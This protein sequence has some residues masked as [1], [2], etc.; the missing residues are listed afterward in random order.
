MK[1]Y[2]VLLMVDVKKRDL[3]SLLLI[4]SI[5]K[6]KYNCDVF[7]CRNGLEKMYVYRFKID[8][9]VITNAISPNLKKLCKSLKKIG[10]KIIILPSEGFHKRLVVKK[11]HASGGI[12]M[13]H[14]YVDKIF[15]WNNEMFK[16]FLKYK[17]I[18]PKNLILSGCQRLD[19]Y[20]NKFKLL[21]KKI[22]DLNLVKKK[23]VLLIATNYVQADR[24]QMDRISDYEKEIKSFNIEFKN[25]KELISR[26]KNDQKARLKLC[27]LILKISKLQKY[28]IILKVHPFENIFF[29]VKFIKE[30]NIKNVSISEND[31]IEGL[32]EYCDILIARSCHTQLEAFALNKFTIELDLHK[33]D[34]NIDPVRK[35]GNYLVKNY[36]DLI[37]AIN[38]YKSK[39]WEKKL[40]KARNKSLTEFGNFGKKLACEKI[41]R[42]ISKTLVKN[43]TSINTT[44]ITRIVFIIKYYILTSFNF[45]LHDLIYQGNIKKKLKY[46]KVYID[47]HSRIDKHIHNED[48]TKLNLI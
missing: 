20:K 2:K 19:I 13:Y 15:V 32:L 48:I 25:L 1:K 46:K 39:K 18:D 6:K 24:Y 14:N 38:S 17:S 16:L 7:Y 11:A 29:W 9:V 3:L 47:K 4:G 30:N 33:F 26:C 41:A 42:E 12:E 43:H 23:T 35:R 34:K 44:F 21:R 37:N 5:L 45:L 31:F 40:K 28:Q 8:L 10:T 36:N 22:F 27:K